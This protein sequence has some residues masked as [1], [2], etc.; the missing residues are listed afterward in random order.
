MYQLGEASLCW[1]NKHPP[2]LSG[3]HTQGLSLPSVTC[4][5]P[6]GHSALHPLLRDR[7]WWSLKHLG[8]HHTM[9]WGGPGEEEL[10]RILNQQLMLLP[11]SNT[12]H[13]HSHF[14]L[15]RPDLKG[16]KKCNSPLGMRVSTTG[17][18]WWWPQSSNMCSGLYSSSSNGLRVTYSLKCK[19]E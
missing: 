13:L 4:H 7:G 11:E 17:E 3:S 12:H 10:W 15:A 1:D 19:L 8:C 6:G 9:A 16:V 2:S 18:W 5:R 14:Y